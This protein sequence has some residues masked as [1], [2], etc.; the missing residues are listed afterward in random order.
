MWVLSTEDKWTYLGNTHILFLCLKYFM[1]II[2]SEF[3]V[4]SSS[5]MH[6]EF[7]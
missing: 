3:A 4:L 7:K 6:I 2:Y 5:I 1:L